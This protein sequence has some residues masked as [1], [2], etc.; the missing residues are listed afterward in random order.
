MSV[1]QANRSRKSPPAIRRA[2]FYDLDG[3]LTNLNLL[4]ATLFFVTN[5]AEWGG[6]VNSLFGLI[7]RLPRIAMAELRDRYLLNVTLFES[8]K[9]LS[10]D[11]LELLGDEYCERFLIPHIYPQAI[12]IIERNRQIGLEPVIVSGSPDFVVGPLARRLNIATFAANRLLFFRN[13][14]TGRL[15]EPVLAGQEKTAWCADYAAEHGI[16]LSACWGYAD[17][18]YDL[19]FLTALGHPVAVN[20]DR[21]LEASARSRQWPIVRFSKAALN[22]GQDEETLS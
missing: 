4:H 14:A 20:P 3:T 8:F 21:R 5:L 17:S 2:A 12:E 6:R 18:H 13:R 22:Q 10:R 16:E 15:Q 7:S 1:Q 9:G 19:P 11:R